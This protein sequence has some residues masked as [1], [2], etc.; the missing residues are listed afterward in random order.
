V[1]TSEE[2]EVKR[3]FGLGFLHSNKTCVWG[4]KNS[5]DK[6]SHM[7]RECQ[8]GGRKKG[9]RGTLSKGNGSRRR[10]TLRKEEKV[11]KIVGK[12]SV[13]RRGRETSGTARRSE[14]EVSTDRK[15]PNGNTPYLGNC[16]GGDALCRWLD[17]EAK[18]RLRSPVEGDLG[19]G[20]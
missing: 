12:I 9:N 18:K 14:R 3:S 15:G 7:G 19:L 6:S 5:R 2:E 20:A 10:L 16:G 1:T 8:V 4:T 11:L 17:G 13:G